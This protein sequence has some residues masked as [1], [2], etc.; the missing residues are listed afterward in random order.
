MSF[1]FFGFVG[2]RSC[3]HGVFGPFTTSDRVLVRLSQSVV[4]RIGGNLVHYFADFLNLLIG[5]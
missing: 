5:R 4:N 1:V 2:H 3:C